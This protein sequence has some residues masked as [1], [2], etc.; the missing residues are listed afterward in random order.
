MENESNPGLNAIYTRIAVEHLLL[1]DDMIK[2][3]HECLNSNLQDVITSLNHE[4][5]KLVNT[6]PAYAD[7]QKIIDVIRRHERL[8][9]AR[10]EAL[11]D[12]DGMY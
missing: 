10:N 8:V 6:N 7:A 12:M 11:D 9:R 1:I 2:Q 4:R 3:L 5:D